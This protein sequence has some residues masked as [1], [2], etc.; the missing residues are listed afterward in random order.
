[1]KEICFIGGNDI[2]PRQIGAKESLTR[3]GTL[4]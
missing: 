2:Q 3:T 1:M 4:G